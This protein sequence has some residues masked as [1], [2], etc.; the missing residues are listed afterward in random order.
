MQAVGI[1]PEGRRNSSPRARPCAGPGVGVA[2][3]VRV[4][5]EITDIMLLLH[6]G[7]P[8]DRQME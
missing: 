3:G 5:Q 6:A 2:F 8:D 4:I 1:E 7:L